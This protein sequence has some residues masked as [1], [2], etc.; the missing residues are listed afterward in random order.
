MALNLILPLRLALV[1]KSKW[2]HANEVRLRSLW[3]SLR[4]LLAVLLFVVLSFGM[5][6][7][8]LFVFAVHCNW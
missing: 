6:R 4:S 3:L 2:W 1:W 5:V 8:S 7:G